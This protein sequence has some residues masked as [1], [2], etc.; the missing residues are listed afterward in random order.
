[1]RKINLI[2]N[3]DK[4]EGLSGENLCIK[5]KDNESYID[6]RILINKFKLGEIRESIDI[7]ILNKKFKDAYVDLSWISSFYSFRENGIR[8]LLESKLEKDIPRYIDSNTLYYVLRSVEKID[9]F[10]KYYDSSYNFEENLFRHISRTSNLDEINTFEDMLKLI[11]KNEDRFLDIDDGIVDKKLIISVIDSLTENFKCKSTF[12]EDIDSP[13]G[14]STFLDKIKNT[15]LLSKYKNSDRLIIGREDIYKIEDIGQISNEIV[16]LILDKNTSLLKK[17][18]SRLELENQKI[19]VFSESK[20]L[21]IDYFLENVSGYFDFEIEV[22]LEKL[23]NQFIN[24]RKPEVLISIYTKADRAKEKFAHIL[25][26]EDNYREKLEDIKDFI[27]RYRAIIGYKS[28]Y[29]SIEEWM[30]F[31]RINY[32]KNFNYLSDE[33]DIYRKLEKLNLNKY[34]EK[35]IETTIKE[36][37][38]ELNKNY[39]DFLMDNYGDYLVNFDN[40]T[41]SGKLEEVRSIVKSKK[42]ILIVIDAMKWTVWEVVRDILEKHDYKVINDNNTTLSMLPSVTGVSRLAL[43]AG[44]NYENIV[45]QKSNKLYTYNL[46]DEESHLKRYFDDKRVVLK[47]GSKNEFE[48]LLLEEADLYSFIFTDIDRIFHNT[49]TINE[50]VIVGL[51]EEQIEMFIEKIRLKFGDDEYNLILT[52][53][54]GMIDTTNQIA[55]NSDRDLE[56]YLEKKNINYEKH[57]RYY[58]IYSDEILEEKN[59][60]EIVKY[61]KSSEQKEKW[62]LIERENMSSYGLPE[63]IS[64]NNNVAWAITKYPYYLSKRGGSNVHGGL[65]MEETIIPFMVMERG[66]IEL[67]PIDISVEGNLEINKESNISIRLYNKNSINI[68]EITIESKDIELYYKLDCIAPRSQEIIKYNLKPNISGKL[69]FKITIEYS[70]RGEIEKQGKE[71]ELNIIES[72]RE[73]ISKKVNKSRSLDL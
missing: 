30:M 70:V 15:I 68:R 5:V 65:S 19:R 50:K 60:D 45:N 32:I 67:K 33:N 72:Y 3:L 54:H 12:M 35:D 34:T 58:R 17:L 18:N 46:L 59:Y 36:K 29:S 14:F 61:F 25:I 51:L 40:K 56:R 31:Y 2:Y 64:K 4:I 24:F 55:I 47:K 16:D 73:K 57:G 13:N 62:H 11:V 38:L 22:F 44:N 8:S 69:N 28:E 48:E 6:S 1:M 20:D 42:V 21:S 52:T 43:F 41:I 27:D 66:E 53:D 10:C 63:K 37:E 39:E 71:I 9:E 49:S 7:I 23:K 26:R